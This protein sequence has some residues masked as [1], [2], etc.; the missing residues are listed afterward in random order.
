MEEETMRKMKMPWQPQ[1]GEEEDKSPQQNLVEEAV[2]SSSTAQEPKGRKSPGHRAQGQAADTDHRDLRRKDPPE[3][4]EA[5]GAQSWEQL[6]DEEKPHKCLECG[7]SFTQSFRLLTHLQVHTGQRRW[8][9]RE[10]GKRY[11]HSSHLYH[12]RVHTTERPYTCLECGKSFSVRSTLTSHQKGHT[13]EQPHECSECGKKAR[14]SLDLLKHSTP[15][16][17]VWEDL[18]AQL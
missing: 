12:Q 16:S 5:A 7:K 1:A 10:C 11:R 17:R 18:Q 3:A 15:V 8:E 13:G 14:S 4:G 9:C 2:L 6:Q